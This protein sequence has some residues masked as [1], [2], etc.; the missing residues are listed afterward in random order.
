MKF[1]LN[2]HY[3]G[4]AIYAFL[5]IAAA[6]LFGEVIKNFSSVLGMGRAVVQFIQPVV[7]GFVFAFLLNPM[8]RLYDDRLLGSLAGDRLK[9]TIRRTLALLLTYL[10]MLL[11]LALFFSLIIPQ[12][13]VSIERLFGLFPMYADALNR[14][15]GDLL[16][17]LE[18]LQLLNEGTEMATLLESVRGRLTNMLG[19]LFETAYERVAGLLPQIFSAGARVTGTIVDFLLGVIISIYFL[20]DR[21]KLF[22]Q[23]RKIG[24]ALFSERVSGLFYGIAL[25]A[26]RV[27]T[28]FIIGKLIDSLIIGFLC[29]IGVSIMGMPFA[30]LISVIVGVTNVI[31]YFGPF[32]GAIPCILIILIVDPI[33]A[34]WFAFF[35]L[36]L[37]QFDGNV[38]GPKIL[39]DTTGLSALWVIFAI[40]LFSGIFGVMGMFIGVPLFAV[41]YTIIKRVVA[42]LLRRKGMSDNTRDYDSEKNPLIK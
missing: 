23:L 34:L 22:A 24:S 39:G 28:G 8:L 10:T 19:S 5:V 37:Q 6:M 40:M 2:K 18:E 30:M 27:F 13:L 35:I 12:L 4:I 38:L 11:L 15:Y 7:Y 36:I 29:Y 25:D 3:T 33:K 1:R 41:L 17:W 42:F 31:P 20:F 9:P 21:E 16:T 14:W 32:I 26:N